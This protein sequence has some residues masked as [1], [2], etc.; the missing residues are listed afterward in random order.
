[1]TVTK[2]I[3][4]IISENALSVA[5]EESMISPSRHQHILWVKDQFEQAQFPDFVV[6]VPA[7]H[8]VS[9][10]FSGNER[11]ILDLKI[12]VEK[13]LNELYKSLEKQVMNNANTLYRKPLHSNQNT[14]EIPV[15]YGAE[16]G[17]DLAEVASI[18]KLSEH[19][20][21]RIH[22]Q[23]IYYVYMIGF[24][25]GFPYLGGLSQKIFTPRKASPRLK[26]DAGSVGIGG[27]QT[28]VYPLS[29]PGGWQIIGKTDFSFF[30]EKGSFKSVIKAGDLVKFSAV[31][32]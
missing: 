3:V 13:W 9:L 27:E 25:A 22:T 16:Y 28:G 26:V 6:S 10:F 19:E 32:S 4:Q 15:H 12:L 31:D 7:Y 30:Q 14:W 29:A 11:S 5:W 20:V 17:P 1:M 21:V 24:T 8:T 2:P 23:E 18:N